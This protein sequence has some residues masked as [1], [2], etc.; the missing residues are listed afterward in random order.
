MKSRPSGRKAYYSTMVVPIEQVANQFGRLSV[1]E[2]PMQNHAWPSLEIVNVLHELIRAYDK[3]YEP[4]VLTRS[5][6]SRIPNLKQLLE[7][8]HVQELEYY[9][10]IWK[11]E[12]EDCDICKNIGRGV[13]TTRGNS[14]REVLRFMDKP[15]PDPTDK[16]KY[17]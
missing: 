17:L 16:E 8:Y 14:R 13:H 11:C 1:D 15:I 2:G 5:Q 6:L 3:D 10:E 9:F 7:S 4:N 12:E